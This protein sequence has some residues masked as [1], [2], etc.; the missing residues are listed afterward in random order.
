LD[1]L[2]PSAVTFAQQAHIAKV[3]TMGISE[4]TSVILPQL[5][6]DADIPNKTG[7]AGAQPLTRVDV[8]VL[9]AALQQVADTYDT[10]ED[11]ELFVKAAGMNALFNQG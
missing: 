1:I 5:D 2:R 3:V 4:T 11:L 8:E 7:L 6:L 10:D 9:V